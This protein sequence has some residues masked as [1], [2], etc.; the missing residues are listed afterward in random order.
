MSDNNE[1]EYTEDYKS[2]ADQEA[3]SSEGGSAEGGSF[4]LSK[5]GGDQEIVID[6]TPPEWSLKTISERLSL[7][8][9]INEMF[10]D[11][12]TVQ[13][14]T[15]EVLSRY[16]DLQNDIESMFQVWKMNF[17]DSVVIKY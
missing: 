9:N 17:W 3:S 4:E 12:I 2:I 11:P 15:A 6:D 8:K 13:A 1:E 10:V 14:R 16:K 5:S 7:S